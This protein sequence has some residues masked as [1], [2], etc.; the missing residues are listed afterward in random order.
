MILRTIDDSV[1]SM[2]LYGLIDITTLEPT[3][4]AKNFNW[5]KKLSIT[6]P[7]SKVETMTSHEN[8]NYFVITNKGEIQAMFECECHAIKYN[9]EVLGKKNAHVY[10]HEPR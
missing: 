1:N 10:E 3:A 7:H 9:L 4:Y 2:I 5:L 8:L 6:I